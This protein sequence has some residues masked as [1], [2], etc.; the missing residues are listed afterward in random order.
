[1]TQQSILHLVVNS[2]VNRGF[3]NFEIFKFLVSDRV[4]TTNVHRH[5][6]FM[7]L[8]Q[9][10]ATISH[11]TIFKMAA[12]RHLGLL[13]VF[14]EQLVSSG[15]LIHMYV[16][17]CKIS[18]KSAKRFLRY[19]NFS[20]IKIA[21]VRHFGFFK[22]WFFKTFLRVWR[23]NMHQDAKCHPNRSNRCWTIAIYPNFR[24]GGHPPFW[25]CGANFGTTHNE[26]LMVF[27]TVQNLVAISLDI[28]IIEKV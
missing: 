25:I 3:L 28:L 16:P 14:L 15:G 24:Y 26:N 8:G 19:H 27:I 17:P 4:G 2:V 22:N 23:A 1:M 9:M 7:K 13:N 5:T 21:A 6:N 20:I 11:L 18:S 12:V 10:I